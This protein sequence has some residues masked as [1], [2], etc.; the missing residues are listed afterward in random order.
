MNRNVFLFWVA[1][2]FILGISNPSSAY[3]TKD[4][5]RL[6]IY[7]SNP[8]IEY[9]A[10][11]IY[12]TIEFE[13]EKTK[14]SFPLDIEIK[15][16]QPN[17]YLIRH[18]LWDNFFWK[19]DTSSG[20]A[21]MVKREPSGDYE[22][23]MS[24][25]EAREINLPDDLKILSLKLRDLYMELNPITSSARMFAE[26][27]IIVDSNEFEVRR[28]G[29]GY[30]M[31]HKKARGDWPFLKFDMNKMAMDYVWGIKFGTNYDITS[32]KTQIRFTSQPE[33]KGM[34]YFERIEPLNELETKELEEGL[35]VFISNA[36]ISAYEGKPFQ[37]INEP[38]LLTNDLYMPFLNYYHTFHLV[39]ASE[40]ALLVETYSY[41]PFQE[42]Y[43]IV[44]LING[45]L[46]AIPEEYFP[47]SI[48]R[49]I[50][51]IH[52]EE[53]DGILNIYLF[54]LD[55]V[56]EDGVIVRKGYLS[57]DLRN[58]KI[59]NVATLYEKEPV[60]GV[61]GY[62]KNFSANQTNYIYW[63]NGNGFL[64]AYQDTIYADPEGQPPLTVLFGKRDDTVYKR[65]IPNPLHDELSREY[66][67]GYLSFCG[68]DIGAIASFGD[69]LIYGLGFYG[70]EGCR[71][72][73]GIGTI[74]LGAGHIVF[75]RPKQIL[76]CSIQKILPI[77]KG[78]YLVITMYGG[79]GW[80][81]R[82]GGP[83]I[84]FQDREDWKAF[85]G[86]KGDE[87]ILDAHR[88]KD[89]LWIASDRKLYR[90]DID[91]G[92]KPVIYALSENKSKLVPI[93]KEIIARALRGDQ[94]QKRWGAF[95]LAEEPIGNLKSEL[96][97][98]LKSDDIELRKFALR[99]IGRAKLVGV[100]PQLMKLK[101]DRDLA[102]FLVFALYS[103][104]DNEA[105]EALESLCFEGNAACPYAAE[106]LYN[107]KGGLPSLR[108]LLV[109]VS[110]PEYL[111][112][113]IDF[114]GEAK[115]KEITPYLIS[116]GEISDMTLRTLGGPFNFRNQWYKLHF[117]II[118]ALGKAGDNSSASWLKEKYKTA[119]DTNTKTEI[120]Q[121][122]ASI[123]K[124]DAIP[125]LKEIK[126]KE[127]NAEILRIIWMLLPEGEK[128]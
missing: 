83:W 19:I 70:G 109:K 125:Y 43:S 101:G 107:L 29:D 64:I 90:F 71:S 91:K 97:N 82:C 48:Y 118:S 2:L 123:L 28:A 103:S 96:L 24:G 33:N 34:E 41:G 46:T 61:S 20:K 78:I 44:N 38:S 32:V 88:D 1:I 69:K 106:A 98:L 26:G 85:T 127:S 59:T 77:A 93:T 80:T 8:S 51:E 111:A 84:Y 113:I 100:I 124:E 110:N 55:S 126:E 92:G 81:G 10:N 76:K 16:P 22:T 86:I 39:R 54:T 121:A 13:V 60:D 56:L 115:D 62:L 87:G 63:T 23:L 50:P 79:E 52:L 102:E 25:V 4:V 36:P 17:I 117:S 42:R 108:K 35:K 45:S 21:Y 75:E 58:N 15:N 66:G 6:F 128:Q 105:K 116:L 30:H 40:S 67:D 94:N 99:G 114:L 68:N 14:P 5:E 112:S 122:I 57:F 72:F 74:N 89:Y 12:P 119:I 49:N 18:R 104:G 3:E 9:S 65:E 47:A 95:W 7:F 73:G 27:G 120:L 53:A 37:H 31:R 11:N